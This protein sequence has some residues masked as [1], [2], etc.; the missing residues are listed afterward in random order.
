MVTKNRNVNTNLFGSIDY[1]HALRN[2]GFYAI[3]HN[4]YQSTHFRSSNLT[5]YLESASLFNLLQFA[6]QYH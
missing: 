5:I 3:D 4:I 6:Q 2:L 1:Q